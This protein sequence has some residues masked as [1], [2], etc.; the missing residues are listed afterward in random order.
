MYYSLD[1]EVHKVPCLWGLSEGASCRLDAAMCL[2]LNPFMTALPIWVLAMK[3][4]LFRVPIFRILSHQAEVITHFK[5][6]G[7]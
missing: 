7:N 2:Y 1:F 4:A 3:Q 5:N 6:E